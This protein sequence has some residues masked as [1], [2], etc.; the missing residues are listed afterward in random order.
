MLDVYCG[1]NGSP[2]HDEFRRSGVLYE[3]CR[4]LPGCR[5]FTFTVRRLLRCS[6][7]IRISWSCAQVFLRWQRDHR[8]R[9]SAQPDLIELHPRRWSGGEND[10]VRQHGTPLPGIALSFPSFHHIINVPE[11]HLSMLSPHL[12]VPS[13]K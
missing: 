13:D 7:R 4:T 12:P 2:Q 1:S 8:L 5:T 10:V 11:Q 3:Y 6:R 9:F